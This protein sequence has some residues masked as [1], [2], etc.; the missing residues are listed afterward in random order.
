LITLAL[1]VGKDIILPILFSILLANIL[2]PLV[3]YLIKIKF[4]KPIAILLP[5]ILSIVIGGILIYFLSS[6]VMN[7][8]DDVPA[9]K[10]RVNEVGHSFQVW[11]RQTTAITIR[12]QN[13]YIPVTLLPIYHQRFSHSCISKRITAKSK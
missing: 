9:L 7:F 11:F 8:I 1:Y 10:V 13:K 3:H 4:N 6:Q 5:L 12:E 2:L